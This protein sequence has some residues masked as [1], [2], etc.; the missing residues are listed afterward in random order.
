M[1]TQPSS[2][3][4]DVHVFRS[5]PTG[6]WVVVTDDRVVAGYE[7][8]GIAARA[9]RR[10]AVGRGVGLVIHRGIRSR[11]RGGDSRRREATR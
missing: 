2:Q 10:E 5:A 7:T 1:R 8:R 6:T 11:G 3:T 4:T 9:G